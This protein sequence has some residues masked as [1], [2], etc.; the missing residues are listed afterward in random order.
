MEARDGV[1]HPPVRPAAFQKII[2]GERL[3]DLP[4]PRRALGMGRPVVVLGALT[5]LRGKRLNGRIVGGLDPGAKAGDRREGDESLNSWQLSADFLHHL[6]DE[7]IAEADARQALLAI[8]DRIE[9]RDPRLVLSD[10]GAL[11]G[12]QRRDRVGRGQGQRH[13][14]E[15][16]RLV[17]HRRM[18]ERVAAPVHRIDAPAQ[19]LPVADL[20]D[21]LV[22]D[23]LGEDRSRRRPV[24]PAQ[25]EKAAIEP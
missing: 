16:Q 11:L 18:E 14:D 9:C 17:D 12:E 4:H 5:R 10:M 21:G 20:V 13:L 25:D 1:D 2:G 19:V 24:D 6:L 23:D 3:Q 15:D 8:R 22:A 7:K